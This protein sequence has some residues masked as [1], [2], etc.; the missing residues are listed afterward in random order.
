MSDFA[1]GGIARR[2]RWPVPVDYVTGGDGRFIPYVPA[3]LREVY[4]APENKT[5]KNRHVYGAGEK[6]VFRVSPRLDEVE[7]K[8]RKLDCGDT[9]SGYELTMPGRAIRN[10]NMERRQIGL[11]ASV[12]MKW[13]SIV[14][15]FLRDCRL[16]SFAKRPTRTR[17][18]RKF[19]SWTN[20]EK[21][22]LAW[23]FASRPC[24]GG[25]G[26]GRGETVDRRLRRSG[27]GI[28]PT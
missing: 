15:F 11:E 19:G 24:L 1:P 4:E 8:T 28:F 26:R 2:V 9:W 21:R 22:N 23:R 3:E 6:V 12:N 18:R 14:F 10:R 27:V 20:D 5:C 7:F 25:N 16:F 17:K 13:F